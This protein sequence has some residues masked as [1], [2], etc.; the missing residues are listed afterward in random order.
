MV[1]VCAWCDRYLGPDEV[2]V[3]HGICV[4]CTARQHWRDSPVLVVSRHREALV[5]VLRHLLQGSPEVK[6]V[7]ERREDERRRTRVASAT[8]VERRS[9]RDRRRRSDL[10]LV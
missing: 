2:P 6:I 10:T 9:G 4:M 5:P 7:V 1:T 3:T 8:G